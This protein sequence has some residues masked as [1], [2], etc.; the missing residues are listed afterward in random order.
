MAS[1]ED[2]ESVAGF[3][4]A[5]WDKELLSKMAIASSNAAA[6]LVLRTPFKKTEKASLF[7]FA[8]I[9]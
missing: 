8:A 9:V 7:P 4:A 6:G 3:S 5:S 2:G 1:V